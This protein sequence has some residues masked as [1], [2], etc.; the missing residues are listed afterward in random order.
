MLGKLRN[1]SK[2]KLAGVLVVIIIIPF[3]FWGMGSVFS[4][5]NK[6]NLAIINGENISSQDFIDYVNNSNIDIKTL[7]DNIENNVLEELL[8]QL[9]SH[10]LLSLETERISLSLS[11]K[12]LFEHIV[13][14]VKFS[15]ESGVFS[16]LKYEKFLLEN[17]INAVNFEKRL[18]ENI[19]QRNLFQYISGGIISPNFLVKNLFLEN[20]RQINIEFINLEEN[21]KKEFSDSNISEY[22]NNNKDEL[23]KDFININYVK[24]T[25]KDITNKNE[26][27][28]NFFEELDKIENELTNGT[29]TIEIAQ[30]FDLEVKTKKNYFYIDK[31]ELFLKEIYNE[32]KNFKSNILD[33]EDYYII[34]EITNLSNKIPEITNEDFFN[35]VVNKLRNKN[36]FEYNKNILK[37]I[38][39]NK[40]N[41]E[42]FNNIAKKPDAIKKMVINSI[43]DNSFFDIDSLKLLYSVP[44]NDFLLIVD[45]KK[46]VY[47][48]KVKSFNFKDFLEKNEN[49]NK[50]Y[51]QSNYDI[52]NN[53]SSTYDS[54]L[55]NKYEITVNQNTLD[56]LKNFF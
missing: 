56:R 5:G 32:R 20:T 7:K 37:K 36:K 55:N 15:D 2:S 30:K 50:F 13:K 42:D 1:F 53:I 18:K 12:G 38:E 25:P 28:K 8:S 45:N 47:L 23:K 40:F 49:Y 24:F 52:K 51:L 3:V 29:S 39:N 4:G 11:D 33:K 31:D 16:R 10:K 44:Q 41:N 17:N 21:Y 34:Y 27:D 43:N 46:N 6:N 19:T 48:T 14:D 9:I 26:F 22:I 54:L 35:E